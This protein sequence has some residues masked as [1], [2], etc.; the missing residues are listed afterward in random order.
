MSSHSAEIPPLAGNSSTP[1]MLQEI[2]PSSHFPPGPDVNI[3]TRSKRH[4]SF[5]A[6]SAFT[7]SSD[8]FQKLH[9]QTKS[10]FDELQES[11]PHQVGFSTPQLTAQQL[12]ENA[13]ESG[14]VD[15][16]T[17][18]LPPFLSLD[19]LPPPSSSAAAVGSEQIE[20]YPSSTTGTTSCTNTTPNQAA[21]APPSHL[22][23]GRESSSLFLANT[24]YLSDFLTMGSSYGGSGGFVKSITADPSLDYFNYKS[25]AHSD[26][27]HINSS[28]NISVSKS[29]S[30]DNDNPIEK[31]QRNNNVSNETIH[32]SDIPVSYTHLDVYKRQ[33]QYR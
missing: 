26:T 30:N 1:A 2:E 4:A 29:K 24:P 33:T 14:V 10:D 20:L 25:S 11:V 18:D 8:N 6:S 32:Y 7:Y 28:V 12:I 16:E 15:L 27:K 23:I 9:Q 3:P 5:S 17:L 13:I 19:G 22:P 31:I 21:T